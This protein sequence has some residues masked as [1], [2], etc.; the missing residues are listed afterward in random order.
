[1]VGWPVEHSHSPAL[2][3]AALQAAGLEGGYEL[4]PVPDGPGARQGLEMQLERL[5]RGEL[6]GLNVTLP[7]KSR[8]AA[9]LE[10]LSP[11]ARAIGAVN[12]LYR[13][14]GGLR[15]DNTDAPGFL[16]DLA[17][18]HSGP[19]ALALVL[20]AGGSARAVVFALLSQGWRVA[21]AA[22]RLDQAHDLAAGLAPALDGL[23]AVDG[24]SGMLNQQPGAADQMLIPLALAP[25]PLS[26]LSPACALC[27]N[28]TPV[29]M[30]PQGWASPWPSDVPFPRGLAVYDLVYNPSETALLRSARAAGSPGRSGLGMLVEQAALSFELWTG[31]DASR[32]AMWA[33][34]GPSAAAQ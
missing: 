14:E 25:K 29:G 26:Q 17:H 18:L 31:L 33:A 9:M 32:E 34:L 16:A 30:A 8:V 27:V 20:G 22:R 15:G 19:P 10:A 2:H 7:Y 24:A 5:R 13:A 28:C 1:L 6:Q 21:V 4:F 11:A 23:V 12:T 3:L